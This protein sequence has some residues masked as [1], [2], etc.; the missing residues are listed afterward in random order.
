MVNFPTWIPDYDSHSRALLDFFLSSDPTICSAMAFAPLGNSDHVDVSVSIDFPV[1]SQR[2]APFH[3]IA[4]DYFRADWDGL[5][6]HLRDVPWEDI[7]KLG[8]STAASEF[9][10]WIQVGIDVYVPHRKCQAKPHS[11]RWFSAACAAAIVHRHH[12]FCL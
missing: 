9:C 12:F 7:F 8:G 3:R 6:D 5:R 11:S 10:E 1:N 4:Y 2:D